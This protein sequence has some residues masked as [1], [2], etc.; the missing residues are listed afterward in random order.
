MRYVN[1][2]N[3]QNAAEI[4]QET[5]SCAAECF[6]NIWFRKVLDVSACFNDS[7]FLSLL[8]NSGVQCQILKIFP[9]KCSFLQNIIFGEFARFFK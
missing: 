3:L 6:L 1:E 8:Y 9:M 5:F 2:L 7:K 4:L